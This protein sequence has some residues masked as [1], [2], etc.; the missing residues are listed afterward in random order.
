[1]A[2]ASHHR[3]H[4]EASLAQQVAQVGDGG[5]G[6]D[7]RGEPTLPLRLGELE[8]AA[9]LVQRVPT[10]HGPDEHAIRFKD[11]LDLNS[12]GQSLILPL[13]SHQS[14]DE[15][16]SSVPGSPVSALQAGR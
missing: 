14:V 2:A 3:Q 15:A 4:V 6:G 10:H 16:E 12:A 9:Q 13:I 11:L 7:V 1:M 8:G 5:V